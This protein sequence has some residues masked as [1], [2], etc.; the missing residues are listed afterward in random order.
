[1]KTVD[2]KPT[3]AAQP[4]SGEQLKGTVQDVLDST[5]FIDIHTHLFP[6]QFGGLGLW[7][8]DELLTDHYMEAELFRFSGVAPE[9]Y[10]KLN[11]AQRADL[12]WKTLL[13]E[14]S[15]LSEATR[16]VIAVLHALGLSTQRWS[17]SASFIGDRTWKI[18]SDTSFGRRESDRW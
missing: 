10:W 16:G 11:K 5:E 18:I 2:A 1:M 7:G 4:I 9:Q 13:V 17:P 12:V 6:P 8:I 14:N 15:P 3:A